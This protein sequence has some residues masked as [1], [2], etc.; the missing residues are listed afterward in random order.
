MKIT[1]QR[2]TI[3]LI[4]ALIALF[5]VFLLISPKTPALGAANEV[6]A[7][8]A[9]TSNDVLGTTASLIY[10]TSTCG[11]RIISTGTSAIMLTFSDAQGAVP[12][13]VNGIWQA[14]S[15]TVSYSN[16]TYGCSA[17]RAFSYTTATTTVVETK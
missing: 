11:A 3:Y 7:T 10:A 6:Q 14:A 17:V 1:L 9:T 2:S 8:V 12:T 15:T 5:A 13:G 4:A 16:G